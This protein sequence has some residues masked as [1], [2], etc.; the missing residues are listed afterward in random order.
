MTPESALVRSYAEANKELVAA[1][2]RYLV[3]LGRSPNTIRNYNETMQR[4]IEFLGSTSLIEAD[5]AVLRDFLASFVSRGI[6]AHTTHRHYCGLR[7][8]YRSVLLAGESNYDPTFLLSH[9]KIPYRLPVVLFVEECIRLIN[10]ARDPFER[11][12][13][14]VLYSTAV[15]VSELVNLRL[16]DIRW[17]ADELH[18]IRIHGGKGNKDRVAYFGSKA[19]AA[20]RAYQEFRPS[21]AG[22]LFEAPARQGEVF[23]Y[24]NSWAG[25][26]YV[27]K[28]QRTFSIFPKRQRGPGPDNHTR[29]EAKREFD[30][31]TSKIPGFEPIPP[32]QYT[33]RAIRLVIKRL[34][35]RAGLVHVHPHALRRA[36][37]THLLQHGADLRAVQELLGHK[38]IGATVIYTH[39]TIDDLKAAV[40][41]GPSSRAGDGR[42]RRKKRKVR[43]KPQPSKSSRLVAPRPTPRD[44]GILD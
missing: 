23:R 10:A 14:E 1:F 43:L 7:A 19:A 25:R 24:G 11:A 38:D 36:A 27:D 34:A 31:L 41:Q 29:D 4:L 40:R 2:C 39:L 3:T 33:A 44:K 18:S 20:I 6:S 30:R 16:D 28:V 32:R 35:D 12:V 13:T 26:F 17:G 8:F 37:A 15:R 21:K 22:F 42:C 9:R 5:R